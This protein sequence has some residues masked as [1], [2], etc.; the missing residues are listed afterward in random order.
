MAASSVNRAINPTAVQVATGLYNTAP[1]S[2]SGKSVTFTTTVAEYLT[3]KSLTS[4]PLN[5]T[6]FYDLQFIFMI[7]L[8]NGDTIIPLETRVRPSA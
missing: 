7:T 5:G 3:K 6:A 2:A 4:L 8:D 1:I